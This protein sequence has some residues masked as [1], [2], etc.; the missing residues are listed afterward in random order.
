M[1]FK[2]ENFL[3]SLYVPQLRSVVHGARSHEHAM[4]I[5]READDLHLVTLQCVI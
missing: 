3:T 5:E 4:W 1:A 2:A